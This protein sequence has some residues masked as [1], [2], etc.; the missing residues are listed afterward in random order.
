M[1]KKGFLLPEKYKIYQCCDL[2]YG[3]ATCW[4]ERGEA[5]L[6]KSAYYGDSISSPE[7]CTAHHRGVQYE[8]QVL[9]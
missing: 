3:T 8:G 2:V 1:Y 7:L 5:T 6:L 4:P 9:K